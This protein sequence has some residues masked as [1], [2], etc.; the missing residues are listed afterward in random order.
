MFLPALCPDDGDWI[1]KESRSLSL[2]LDTY[3]KLME[4]FMQDLYSNSTRIET[5]TDTYV[6]DES[7]LLAHYGLKYRSEAKLE[8]KVLRH[9]EIHQHYFVETWM[10]MK[11][12]KKGLDHHKERILQDISQSPYHTSSTTSSSES[13][14]LLEST[15]NVTI[16]KTRVNLLMGSVMMEICALENEPP[17]SIASRI[18]R[19]WISICIEG[20]D[21][22]SLK[23]YLIS[24]PHLVSMWN[25][26]KYLSDL[27]NILGTRLLCDLVFYP[28]LGGYPTWIKAIRQQMNADSIDQQFGEICTLIDLRDESRIA[29][30][31]K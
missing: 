24:S 4:T 17:P 5:R 21:L 8:L 15:S 3:Q 27:K 12:G 10:K 25:M 19:N 11:Y 22:A 2:F 9:R 1:S 13:S 26:L 31:L 18:N 16:K 7:S 20:A 28:V 29:L 6:N 30:G 23:S 14:N